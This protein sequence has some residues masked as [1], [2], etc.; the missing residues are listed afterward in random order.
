MVHLKVPRP[1][2]ACSVALGLDG[3]TAGAGSLGA[4][5]DHS[6]IRSCS[7]G[8]KQGG[9]LAARGGDCPAAVHLIQDCERIRAVPPGD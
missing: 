5:L 8:Q 4:A 9:G 6:G 7:A 2:M 1:S 3:V